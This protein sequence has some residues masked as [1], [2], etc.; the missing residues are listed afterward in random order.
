MF[1][2]WG[3]PKNIFQSNTPEQASAPLHSGAP[4]GERVGRFRV[5][6]GGFITMMLDVA[7]GVIIAAAICGLFAWG[8]RSVV[9]ARKFWAN[10]RAGQRDYTKLGLGET[11]GWI[12]IVI[13]LGLAI[14]VVL[15]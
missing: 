2:R 11:G 15:I 14:V 5:I 7:G 6:D 1:D 13:S 10:G 9:E 4:E 8:V 3:G 12:C